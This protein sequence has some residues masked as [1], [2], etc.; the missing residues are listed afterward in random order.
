MARVGG[1]WRKRDFD[2]GEEGGGAFG[3][4][5]DG[6]EGAGVEALCSSAAVVDGEEDRGEGRD[7]E[8]RLSGEGGH[9]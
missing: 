4:A 2:D 8:K 9:G 7:G 5:G 6:A 1:G 3:E